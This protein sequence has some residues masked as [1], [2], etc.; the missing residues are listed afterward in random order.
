MTKRKGLDLS[1]KQKVEKRKKQYRES[2]YKHRT[3]KRTYIPR[4]RFASKEEQLKHQKARQKANKTRLRKVKK[5]RNM[6]NKARV[7]RRRKAKAALKKRHKL[8]EILQENATYT[9]H[10][11]L[12]LINEMKVRINNVHLHNI[13]MVFDIRVVSKRSLISCEL[14]LVPA[15]GKF[16]K[17]HRHNSDM[18]LYSNTEA[19]QFK[20]IMEELQQH[21]ETKITC[22]D[23]NMCY[24]GKKIVD[25][26][27]EIYDQTRLF[28][29]S[30]E[31]WMDSDTLEVNLATENCLNVFYEELSK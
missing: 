6:E 20:N 29:L 15:A 18:Y 9:P 22:F 23:S 13:S 21:Y 10:N 7:E 1:P 12:S 5:Y 31:G 19:E 14:V 2:K 28:D 27:L 24:N 16:I 17:S 3:S 26:F 4:K 11:K 8:V 25:A 30:A